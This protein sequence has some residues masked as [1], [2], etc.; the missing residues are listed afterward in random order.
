MS[1]LIEVY[2]IFRDKIGEDEAKILVE[3]IEESRMERGNYI[4]REEFK[5]EF[6]IL[7]EEVKSDIQSVKEELSNR[8]DKIE[9][10]LWWLI[11]L[12]I[13]QWITVIIA[14]FRK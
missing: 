1:K 14:L 13:A 12:F 5:E 3:A 8:M 7:R 6:R 10:R 9:A 2:K 4:T 11:G